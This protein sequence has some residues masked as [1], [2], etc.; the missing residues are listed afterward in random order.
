MP[1]KIGYHP[2]NVHLTLAARWPKAFS[3]LA[4]EFIPYTV[5]R[6]TASRLLRGEIDIGGTG[7]TPPIVAASSGMAVLYAAASAFRPANGVIFVSKTSAIATIADLKGRM[8]ALL[9]GSFL[10]YL[11]AKKLEEI[12]LSLNSVQRLDIPAA[13]SAEAL[14]SGQV[15]AWAAM[16]PH[17][18][19]A[20]ASGEFRILAHCGMTIPNRSVFWTVKD[21]ELP[22][23]TISSF[24]Y[25]LQ[26]LGREIAADPEQAAAL[27]SSKSDEHERRVWTRVVRGRD[28]SVVPADEN[29]L[30][31]QQEEAETLFRHGFLQSRVQVSADPRVN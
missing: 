24:V 10:T 25:E 16:A 30:R 31:E 21:R 8:I 9:D 5:G 19:Q 3:G 14:R 20:A 7:S 26:K 28:W 23:E 2:S 6:E 4:P 27:I 18:E 29:I 17:A 11:L 22:N 12:G 13:I 15:D 1:L